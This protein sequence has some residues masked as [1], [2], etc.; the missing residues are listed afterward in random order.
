[1]SDLRDK[2]MSLLDETIELQKKQTKKI[3]GKLNGTGNSNLN[4]DHMTF[5]AELNELIYDLSGLIEEIDKVKR[6]DDVYTKM[7]K[8]MD[9][10]IYGGQF[11]GGDINV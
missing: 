5:L 6:V 11:G 3:D 4:E 10:S 9:D 8:L 7:Q 2:L 1:M